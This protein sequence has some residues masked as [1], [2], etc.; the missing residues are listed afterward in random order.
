MPSTKVYSNKA[1]GSPNILFIC[2]T[3]VGVITELQSIVGTHT[4]EAHVC[5]TAE[6]SLPTVELY[7]TK[8]KVNSLGEDINYRPLYLSS[9]TIVH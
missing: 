8:G 2:V 1:V 9:G 4:L 5:G 3:G 6:S 7:L